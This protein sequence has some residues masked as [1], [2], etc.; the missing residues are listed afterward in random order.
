MR[1]TGWTMNMASTRRLFDDLGRAMATYLTMVGA[2]SNQLYVACADRVGA[3]RELK[4][5]Y[6]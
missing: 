5:R 6:F 3:Q 1:V 2:H 4:S